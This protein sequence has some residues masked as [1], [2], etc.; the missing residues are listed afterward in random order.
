[1]PNYVQNQFVVEGKPEDI[2]KIIDLVTITPAFIEQVAKR[3]EG[4]DEKFKIYEPTEEDLGQISFERLIPTP[5]NI[6][7]AELKVS[8]EK[9]Y[10]K[11]NCWYDWRCKHWGCKWDADECYANTNASGKKW[12]V[13]FTTPWDFPHPYMNALCKVV[14]ENNC[15]LS[16]EFA[17]EDFGSAM[18]RFESHDVNEEGCYYSIEYHNLDADL[19]EEVWGFNP[20]EED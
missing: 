13:E 3:N 16:G 19:Y 15:T 12:F 2:K 18:G 11:E 5:T 4:L 17:D 10:G 8:D 14:V 7:Q 9:K 1:M 20:E 6:F